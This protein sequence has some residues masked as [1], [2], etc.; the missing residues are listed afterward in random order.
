MQSSNATEN[1]TVSESCF[2][3][4]TATP[5]PGLTWTHQNQFST[6]FDAS[7][8]D[9]GRSMNRQIQEVTTPFSS[10]VREIHP[11]IGLGYIFRCNQVSRRNASGTLW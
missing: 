7:R 9:A 3:I 10:F 5:W 1:A 8:R 4:A 2:T 6:R 11:A